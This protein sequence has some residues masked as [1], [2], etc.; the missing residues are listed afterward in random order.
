MS[1]GKRGTPEMRW[2][3]ILS[4]HVRR[5]RCSIDDEGEW[6]NRKKEVNLITYSMG[7]F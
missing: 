3:D 6:G 7:K 1:I 4:Q 5:M 2:N